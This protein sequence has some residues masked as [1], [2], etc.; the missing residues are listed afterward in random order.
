MANRPGILQVAKR[1]RTEDLQVFCDW[2][3]PGE[4]TDMKWRE[5]SEAMGHTYVS[6]LATPHAINVFE[7]DKRW[8]DMAD[9]FVLVLPAGRSAHIELG[10]MAGQGKRTAIL[11]EED[12]DRWDVMY[13]FADVVTSDLDHLVEVLK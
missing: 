10:Y 1:L 7:F 4:K 13:L 3:M 9:A 12:H 8:L 6:A 11:L 2:I 5:F